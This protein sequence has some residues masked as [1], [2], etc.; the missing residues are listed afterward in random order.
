MIYSLTNKVNSL[1]NVFAIDFNAEENPAR[2]ELLSAM[3]GSIFIQF[4]DGSCGD[5]LV[6]IWQKDVSPDC[7][8]AVIIP[9]GGGGGG[10]TFP[11]VPACDSVSVQSELVF[12]AIGGVR[13]WYKAVDHDTIQT[14][15]A[16]VTFSVDDNSTLY[17]STAGGNVTVTLPLPA[18]CHRRSWVVKKTTNDANTITL[19]PLTGNIDN[20]PTH[21]FG[22]VPAGL[23]GESRTL[24]HDGTDWWIV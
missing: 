5:G 20:A 12:G 17:V 21:V 10:P 1:P 2:I 23:A 18:I 11:V 16:S 7:D 8:T 24:Q 22:A 15:S 6:G 3:P 4:R 9:I 19:L 14:A 13:G